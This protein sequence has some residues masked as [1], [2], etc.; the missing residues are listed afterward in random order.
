MPLPMPEFASLKSTGPFKVHEEMRSYQ[1]QVEASIEHTK[2]GRMFYSGVFLPEE[3]LAALPQARERGFR[4]VGEVGGLFSE[5]GLMAFKSARYVVF[6]KGYLA[7]AK[8]KIGDV[9]TL[10]FSPVDPNH[11]EVPH[12]LEQV[13]SSMR[14]GRAGWDKLTSGKRRELAF[15]VASAAREETRMKRA[16]QIVEDLITP[17]S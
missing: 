2:Y 3:L 12:E 16:F 4:L 6:S 11:V 9:V 10:R 14:G 15:R 8:L 17:T 13:L 7:E 1:Y 5:F